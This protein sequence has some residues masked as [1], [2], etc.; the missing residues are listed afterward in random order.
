MFRIY[1]FRHKISKKYLCENFENITLWLDP[2]EDYAKISKFLHAA[3]REK[4]ERWIEWA[5][6][7]IESPNLAQVEIVE[8]ILNE[9]GWFKPNLEKD[10]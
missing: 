4:A 3:D 1:F 6:E 5:K 2:K 9:A 7:N 10:E 8:F